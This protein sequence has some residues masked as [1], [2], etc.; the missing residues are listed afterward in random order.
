MTLEV[1]DAS[2]DQP[3]A[4]FQLPKSL[5]I[6]SHKSAKKLESLEFDPISKLVELHDRIGSQI[7]NMMYDAGGAPKKFSQVAMASLLTIQSKIASDLLR[8]GY[9]RVSETTVIEQTVARPMQIV[10]TRPNKEP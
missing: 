4:K 7:F 2:E 8:Y 1:S 9:S 5:V 6:E 10:L 3:V